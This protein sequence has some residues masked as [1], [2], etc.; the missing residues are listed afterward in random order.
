MSSLEPPLEILKRLAKR[1]VDGALFS[2]TDVIRG[3]EPAEGATREASL[4]GYVD[5]LGIPRRASG[6][7]PPEVVTPG[8]RPI[9]PCK[10]PPV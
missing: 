1:V 7:T 3:P 2:A 8:I 10:L 9:V 5:F 4:S 6:N